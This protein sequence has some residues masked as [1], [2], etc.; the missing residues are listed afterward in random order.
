MVEPEPLPKK[1]AVSF[2]VRKPGET[3]PRGVLAVRRPPDDEELPDVW[4]LPATTLREGESWEEALERAGREKLG[5]TLD[6]GVLLAEGGQDR[7]GSRHAGRTGYH[8]HMRVYEARV[9]EGTPVVPRTGGVGTQYVEWKWA[10]PFELE[11]AAKRGSLCTR[12][13]LEAEER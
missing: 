6:P 8:L 13:Y 5:V 3:D 1:R 12:L 10:E 7:T 2:V 9:V 11:P 4:G